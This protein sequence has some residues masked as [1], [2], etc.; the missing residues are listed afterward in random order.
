LRCPFDT[1]NPTGQTSPSHKQFGAGRLDI[2]IQLDDVVVGI[3]NKFLAGFQENQPHKYVE[4]LNSEIW[5]L[6]PSILASQ[7]ASGEKRRGI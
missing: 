2:L 5:L 3:E 7:L 1:S 4:S 6:H